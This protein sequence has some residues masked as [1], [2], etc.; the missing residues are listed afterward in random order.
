MVFRRVRGSFLLNGRCQPDVLLFKTQEITL[1]RDH[2]LWGLCVCI[3]GVMCN[4]QCVMTRHWSRSLLTRTREILDIKKPAS[5]VNN[6]ILLG[7]SCYASS[8]QHC[9]MTF[10]FN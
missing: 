6:E 7:G 2:R 1:G 8:R 9:V 5:R 3:Y 4:D 10:Y